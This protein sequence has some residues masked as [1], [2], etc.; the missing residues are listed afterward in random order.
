MYEYTYY[1]FSSISC[2]YMSIHFKP[3]TKVPLTDKVHEYF[4]SVLIKC[5][6]EL[7][8]EPSGAL[9]PTKL[10]RAYN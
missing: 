8:G 10:L 5:K 3:G 2:T 4:K 1:I 7:N 6:T 9:W